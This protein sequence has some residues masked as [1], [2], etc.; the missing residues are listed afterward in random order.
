M[1]EERKQKEANMDKLL[2]ILN[3]ELEESGNTINISLFDLNQP[4]L[5]KEFG[6]IELL[7]KTVKMCISRNYLKYRFLGSKDLNG[8]SLTEE[9]QCRAISVI[10]QKKS[11]PTTPAINIGQITNNAPSQ[12]GNNNVQNMTYILTQL[13]DQADK[14]DAPEETKKDFKSKVNALLS[15]PLFNTIISAGAGIAGAVF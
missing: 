13:L 5:I 4:E 1:E 9:G 8:L 11:E 15:H 10:N 7:R 2:V 12:I 6:S 3:D 14:T